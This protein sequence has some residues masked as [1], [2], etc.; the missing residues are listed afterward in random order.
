[1]I[2]TT[3][4]HSTLSLED[5][6]THP[7]EHHEWV[8]GTLQETK[9]M[10]ILLSRIQAQIARLLGNFLETAKQGGAVYTELPC[11]TT[12][13]GRRPD[14]AYL[15]PELVERY[16]AAP[17]LPH[18]PPFVIEVISPPDPAEEL[19]SKA[20][21]YLSSGAVEVWLVFPENQKIMTITEQLTVMFY[22]NQVAIPQ[23]IL[24]DFSIDLKMLFDD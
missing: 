11:R 16:S 7:P 10:T 22:P 6:L 9:G 21:E 8:N 14:I 2:L 18:S 3:I 5:F 24:K 12:Q 15:T 20:S 19:L 1:M 23:A 13:Q 4:A 17:S